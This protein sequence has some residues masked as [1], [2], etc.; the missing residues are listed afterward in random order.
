MGNLWLFLKTYS[1]GVVLVAKKETA[2]EK[3]LGEFAKNLKYQSAIHQK[4]RPIFC[5]IK[6]KSP[7]LWLHVERLIE[8]VAQSIGAPT[9]GC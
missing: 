9:G 4:K 1:F 6:I 7:A 3:I 2:L 5:Y 8:E